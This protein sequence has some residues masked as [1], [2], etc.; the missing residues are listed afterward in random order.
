[1]DTKHLSDLRASLLKQKEEIETELQQ[2]GPFEHSADA[3]DTLDEKAQ[4]VTKLEERRAIDR[5]LTLQLKEI[6][7]T[8][9]K[10]DEGTY[11]ICVT[12]HAP[13]DRRRLAARTVAKLCSDCANRTTIT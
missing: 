9:K 5:S 10:I 1:M 3:S 2:K 7:E 6:E 11:G 13:I 12:C 4:D 8:L